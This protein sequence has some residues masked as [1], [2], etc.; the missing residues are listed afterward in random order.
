MTADINADMLSGRDFVRSGVQDDDGLLKIVRREAGLAKLVM[1]RGDRGASLINGL[2]CPYSV[3]TCPVAPANRVG[4]G[5]T[6]MTVTTLSSAV[7]GDDRISLRR[8]VA[9]ATAQAAGLELP[10]CLDELDFD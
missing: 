5:D 2:S 9:A 4:L 8:G 1:Q 10:R 7:G 3:H 6:L